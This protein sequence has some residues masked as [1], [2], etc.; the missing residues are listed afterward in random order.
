MSISKRQ[1]NE[2]EYLE[3]QNKHKFQKNMMLNEK[4]FAES[5]IYMISFL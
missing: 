4:K 5:Y 2:V 3:P 1:D